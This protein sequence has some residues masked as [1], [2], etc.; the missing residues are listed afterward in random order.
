MTSKYKAKKTNFSLYLEPVLPSLYIDAENYTVKLRK[1]R[2][3]KDKTIRS[4]KEGSEF[5]D[6]GR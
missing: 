5:I 4:R 6:A 3:R 2:Q 1:M